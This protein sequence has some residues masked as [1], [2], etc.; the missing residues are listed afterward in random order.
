MCIGWLFPTS[1]DSRRELRLLGQTVVCAMASERLCVCVCSYTFVYIELL[2][3]N[4][5]DCV[6]ENCRPNN[7]GREEREKK[8]GK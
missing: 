8:R 1:V 2:I 5:A 7:V 3:E 6:I 4:G